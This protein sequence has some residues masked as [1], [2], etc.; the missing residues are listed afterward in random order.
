MAIVT[1]LQKPREKLKARTKHRMVA[2]GHVVA[3]L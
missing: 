1:F 3:R 2:K